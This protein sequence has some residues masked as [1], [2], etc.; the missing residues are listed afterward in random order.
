MERRILMAVMERGILMVVMGRRIEL[1][2]R[3]PAAAVASRTLK[4]N[5]TALLRILMAARVFRAL[6][7]AVAS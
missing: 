5:Y 3:N 1:E 2:C 4:T 7:V 6:T